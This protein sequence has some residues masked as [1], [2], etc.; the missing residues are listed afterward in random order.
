MTGM[1]QNWFCLFVKTFR[2]GSFS[3]EATTVIQYD[4]LCDL[5]NLFGLQLIKESTCLIGVQDGERLGNFL[6][7]CGT[8]LILD[9]KV[10]ETIKKEYSLNLGNT[11]N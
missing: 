9:L 10:S 6:Y 5:Q 4:S 1:G 8:M 3:K 7:F 2:S 11:F